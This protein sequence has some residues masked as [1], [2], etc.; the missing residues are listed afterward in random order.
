[1]TNRTHYRLLAVIVAVLAVTATAAPALAATTP[2]D[3][4]DAR[5]TIEQPGYVDSDVQQKSLNG[6]STY[7]ASG[8]RLLVKPTNFQSEDVVDFGVEEQAGSLTYD[9]S[10]GLFELD[11]NA[12]G[13]YHVYWVVRERYAVTNTTSNTTGNATTTNTTTTRTRRV[14]YS[15]AIR[16]SGG[17]DTVH[18]SEGEHEQLERHSTLG[19]T[20]NATLQEVRSK[21]LP[22]VSNTGSDREL[23]GKIASFYVQYGS[24]LSW[25]TGTLG[26][27]M[28][29]IVLSLAGWFLL[30]VNFGGFGAVIYRLKK[31]LNIHEVTEAEEGALADRQATLDHE[32]RKRKAQNLNW[33]DDIFEQPWT[34]DGFREAF[35]DIP[36]EGFHDYQ[37]TAFLPEVWMRDRLQA[38][39]RA[40]W[41]ARVDR[42]D[43]EAGAEV[44][45][46]A[47]DEDAVAAIVDAELV[48]PETD[49]ES[50]DGEVVALESDLD[51]FVDV[52]DWETEAI[53]R[54][55][56]VGADID[57][58][59]LDTKPPTLDADELT[60]ALDEQSDRFEDSEVAAQYLKEFM[61]T[62]S[63]HEYTDADGQPETTRRILNDFLQ[64]AQYQRDVVKLPGA[65]IIIEHIERALADHDRSDQAHE[66]AEEVRE[67]VA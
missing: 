33:H 55:D 22:L 19:E 59:A 5:L 14:T 8:D 52:F 64:A 13:T 50:V 63:E 60:A 44:D 66:F 37:K 17:V 65:D 3:D 23:F 29:L 20:V 2:P 12:E 25:L 11:A 39:G 32:E 9:D 26:Q 24:P 43:I 16:V 54:F 53:Q 42:A 58:S 34:A 38:M 45:P 18:L 6:T 31:K 57:W 35:G 28:L 62:I 67:G 51:A 36:R 61:E 46:E 56:L 10:L 7:V 41:T 15:A 30:A 27:I 48:A 40:G 1:M 21:N 47:D 49:A 4:R